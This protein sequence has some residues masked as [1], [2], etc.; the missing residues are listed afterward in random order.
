MRERC[1]ENRQMRKTDQESAVVS[2]NVD[3]AFTLHFTVETAVRHSHF[4]VSQMF[5]ND[6]VCVRGDDLIGYIYMVAMMLPLCVFLSRSIRLMWHTDCFGMS[7]VAF[8]CS[9]AIVGICDESI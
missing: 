6:C 7:L 4:T 3:S 2:Y 5:D 9:E 8:V 1:R